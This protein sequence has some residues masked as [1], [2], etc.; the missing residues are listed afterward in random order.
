MKTTE[1][2]QK[3]LDALIA[4]KI[5]C[6]RIIKLSEICQGRLKE[7]IPYWRSPGEINVKQQAVEDSKYPIWYYSEHGY[8][9][10]IVDVNKT[11]I[12]IKPDGNREPTKYKRDTGKR[13]RARDDSC[14]IDV[15]KAL[16]IWSKWESEKA[17]Q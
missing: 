16:E 11:W 2:L 13:E 3:E 8:I 9:E 4:E 1:E 14:N 17:K 15:K 12:V 10:R 5:E 7:L 6:E